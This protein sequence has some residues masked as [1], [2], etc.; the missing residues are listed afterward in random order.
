MVKDVHGDVIP[1]I[2][3]GLWDCGEKRMAKSK[4]KEIADILFTLS[5]DCDRRVDIYTHFIQLDLSNVHLHVSYIVYYCL[6]Y[7]KFKERKYY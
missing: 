7:H 5:C 6:V 2:S 3:H 4:S 1:V